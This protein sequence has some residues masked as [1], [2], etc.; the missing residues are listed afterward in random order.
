MSEQG[1]QPPIPQ[2]P[3]NMQEGLQAALM[4]PLVPLQALSQLLQQLGGGKK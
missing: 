4:L 1:I 2:P 3:A